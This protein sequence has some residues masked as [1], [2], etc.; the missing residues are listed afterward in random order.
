MDKATEEFLQIYAKRHPAAPLPL[1]E[2]TYTLSYKKNMVA[3][4][5]CRLRKRRCI[6]LGDSCEYC[7]SES[8][9]CIS[10]KEYREYLDMFKLK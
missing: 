8:I 4:A 3:C 1:V 2:R 7:T 5:M 10:Q 9:N 6:K